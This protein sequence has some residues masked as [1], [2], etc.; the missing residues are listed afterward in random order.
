MAKRGKTM[1]IMINAFYATSIQHPKCVKIKHM[2][3]NGRGLRQCKNDN[4]LKYQDTKNITQKC[5]YV[6]VYR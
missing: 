5:K 2:T 1:Q 4:N 3:E 6:C